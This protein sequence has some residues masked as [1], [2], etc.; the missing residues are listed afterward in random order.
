MSFDHV[1]QLMQ[2]LIDEGHPGC[3]LHV[4]QHGKLIYEG[5]YQ[6]RL[7]IREAKANEYLVQGYRL[8]L[9]LIQRYPYFGFQS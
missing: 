9:D 1:D 3:T 7:G 8:H 4:T 2:R 6:S 5:C